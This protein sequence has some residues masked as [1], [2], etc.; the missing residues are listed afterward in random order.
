MYLVRRA[1]G[2]ICKETLTT[3]AVIEGLDKRIA[4]E[5]S[6]VMELWDEQRLRVS[7]ST[8]NIFRYH[9]LLHGFGRRV[10]PLAMTSKVH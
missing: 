7:L 8:I 2:L 4:S 5:L 6:D 10:G 1:G 3:K 9:R